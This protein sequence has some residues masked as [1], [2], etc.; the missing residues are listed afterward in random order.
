[1]VVLLSG[2]SCSGQFIRGC[3]VVRTLLQWTVCLWLYCC[4][5]PLAVGSLSVVVLLLGHSCSG[6][7]LIRGCIVVRTLA[8]DS[9]SVIVLLLGHSC[10]GQFIR[11]CIVVRTLLQWTVCLWLYCC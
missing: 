2:H 11:G 8:V 1:V 5:D 3:I 10:S 9:S 6:Q 4:Q 7:Q